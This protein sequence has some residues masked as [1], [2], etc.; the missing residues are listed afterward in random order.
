MKKNKENFNSD[1]FRHFVCIV[2]GDNPD[3]LIA[4]YSM[5]DNKTQTYILYHMKNA[6]KIKKQYVAEYE[7]S[8]KDIEKK[9]KLL[10]DE[11][12]STLRDKIRDTIDSLKDMSNDDFFARL[13]IGYERD[14]EGNIISK[15]NPNAKFTYC[16]VG[17][18]FCMPFITKA[19]KEVMQCKKGD[20][21][22][23]KIH[24]TGAESYERAWEMVIEGD[25]PKD[26]RDKTIYSAMH[27]KVSYF[28]KFG[29][30][31]NYVLSNTSFWGYAFLSDITGWM[32]A[33]NVED[34][35]TWIRNYYD[36]FIKN[37]PDETLLTIYECHI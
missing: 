23:Q 30:K 33:N 29:T 6:E 34:Q 21:D 36:V 5:S 20:I 27:D 1:D 26:D 31:E 8:L 25:T 19:G 32:D 9:W 10:P 11:E 24:L 35:F 3:E 12:V 37:L 16:N 17:K 22:W 28:K 18:L 14:G 4:Q 15:K 13:A 2:A 7:R